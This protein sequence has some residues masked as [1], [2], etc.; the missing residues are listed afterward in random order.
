M[1]S[2]RKA[3]QLHPQLKLISASS[4]SSSQ[5]D[6]GRREGMGGERERE[7]EREREGQ[8]TSMVWNAG[9]HCTRTN[10]V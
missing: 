5:S 8:E 2:R 7:R 4:T 3:P 10:S 6:M 1:V 9:L